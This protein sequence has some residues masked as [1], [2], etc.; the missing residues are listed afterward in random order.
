MISGNN[1]E[2]A[3][4]GSS[5]IIWWIMSAL[6]FIETFLRFRSQEQFKKGECNIELIHVQQ[7]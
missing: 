4:E 6:L 7:Q 5:S 2:E 3:L 1:S